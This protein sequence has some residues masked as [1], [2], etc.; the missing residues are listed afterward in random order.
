[1]SI[2]GIELTPEIEQRL[3][4]KAKR[5]GQSLPIYV[6][7]ILLKDLELREEELPKHSIMELQG[8]GKE[9]W[10]VVNVQEYINE[11]RSEWDHR[12]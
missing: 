4:G 5:R 12:L 2:L 6:Q 1:M 7:S 8:L 3:R 9:A 11:L 10:A